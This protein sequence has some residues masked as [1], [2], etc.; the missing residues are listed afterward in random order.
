MIED[1]DDEENENGG[2]YIVCAVSGAL[3][4]TEIIL[5][6]ADYD[7]LKR[8]NNTTKSQNNII[9]NTNLLAEGKSTNENELQ[10]SSRLANLIEIQ[11]MHKCEIKAIQSGQV[12]KT[13]E[14]VK[15][16]EEEKLDFQ[17][18]QREDTSL[19]K[20]WNMVGHPD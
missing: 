8:S 16:E 11:M 9:A 19:Q 15:F 1:D 2:A 10:E 20:Y 7:N 14:N 13:L 18:L 12:L 4:G 17:K 3:N 5:S 6:P